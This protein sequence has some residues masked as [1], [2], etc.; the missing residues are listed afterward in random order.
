MTVHSQ[1]ALSKS[2][3]G[4][5]WWTGHECK[6]GDLTERLHTSEVERVEVALVVKEPPAN[7]GE[8][9]RSAGLVLG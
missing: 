8:C 4:K 1:H 9:P 5:A 7:A 3:G 2:M 6:N